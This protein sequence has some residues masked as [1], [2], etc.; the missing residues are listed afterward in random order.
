MVLNL[1]TLADGIK[2]YVLQNYDLSAIETI[3]KSEVPKVK[4]TDIHNA[5]IDLAVNEKV[6]NHDE[7]IDYLYKRNKN[8]LSDFF[9][10]LATAQGADFATVYPMF[11]KTGMTIDTMTTLLNDKGID[12]KPLVSVPEFIS[13][14]MSS[15]IQLMKDQGSSFQDIV[16]KLKQNGNDAN[17]ITNALLSNDVNTS[18]VVNLLA[19][20]GYDAT[21]LTMALV[22]NGVKNHQ[23]IVDSLAK[24]GKFDANAITTALS[25]IN[26]NP[27]KIKSLLIKQGFDIPQT[28]YDKINEMLDYLN[29]LKHEWLPEY[30]IEKIDATIQY[31]K[32]HPYI[33]MAVAVAMVAGINLLIKHIKYRRRVNSIKKL[34]TKINKNPSPFQSNIPPPNQL[35]RAQQVNNEKV[36]ENMVNIQF[37]QI[38]HKQMMDRAIDQRP[39]HFITVHR[40]RPKHKRTQRSQQRRRTQ[41]FHFIE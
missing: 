28:Y 10:K 13:Q 31:I 4:Y 9:L 35:A 20:E 8:K 33:S 36:L 14:N 19:N 29:D 1:D 3:I 7:L 6:V 40:G 17:T 23:T 18:T 25:S 24:E 2:K 5:L 27:V 11:Q 32:D 38:L 15:W 21:T 37:K 30:V 16:G 41:S 26:V 34:I 12:I 39:K 22:S